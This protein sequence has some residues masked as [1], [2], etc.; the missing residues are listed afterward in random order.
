MTI[1]VAEMEPD[2][3]ASRPTEP[4]QSP[5]TG[6]S[7]QAFGLTVTDLTEAERKELK[8]KR[9]VRV[10]SAVEA[11]ARAGLREGDVI[12]SVGNTEINSIREFE[13]AAGKVD[14]S[15]SFSLLVLRGELVQYVIV[16]PAR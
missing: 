16:R 9:G 7:G 1:T 6:A 15:K 12:L 13:A 4:A 8:V 5:K 14:Q 11:G 2:Q 10:T 3:T